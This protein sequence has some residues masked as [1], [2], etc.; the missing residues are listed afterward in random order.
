MW[1]G[2]TENLEEDLLVLAV[3]MLELCQKQSKLLVF[4]FRFQRAL[5][6]VSSRLKA[7]E[8]L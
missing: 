8:R 5:K 7:S 6:V 3:D 4:W 2:W 1:V